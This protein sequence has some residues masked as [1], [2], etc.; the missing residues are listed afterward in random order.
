M[1]HRSRPRSL[2]LMGLAGRRRVAGWLAIAGMLLA[3]C[4]GSSGT[5]SNPDDS[6]PER[7]GPQGR[8]AQ[9]VVECELSHLAFDDPLVLPWQP[10]K[11]HLHMFF[12]NRDVD[13]DPG[14][15]DQI[16][17]A[18]TSCDQRQDTASYW[19][20]RPRVWRDELTDSVEVRGVR[21]R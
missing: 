17:S 7:R 6:D 10:G 5:T 1:T 13:S 12:G 21:R 8:V 3:A 4:G 19:A 11:S 9:F 15:N 16:L 2:T 18:E 20:P 14:Y